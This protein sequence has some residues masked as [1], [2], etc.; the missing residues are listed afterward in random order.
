MEENCHNYFNYSLGLGK[1]NTF[2]KCLGRLTYFDHMAVIKK[3]S[4]VCF[5]FVCFVFVEMYIDCISLRRGIT[6]KN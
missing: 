5:F 4:F 6:Q 1:L 2:V 3:C